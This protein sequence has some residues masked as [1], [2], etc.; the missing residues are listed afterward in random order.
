VGREQWAVGSGR[1]AVIVSSVH[2][3]FDSYYSPLQVLT[4]G[5]E[6]TDGVIRSLGQV[7]Q[8]L[9]FAACGERCRQEG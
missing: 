7:M 1:W 4:L 5:M 2:Q 6:Y 9:C 3:L 8:Y